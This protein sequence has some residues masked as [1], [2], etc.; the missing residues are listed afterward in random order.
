MVT[1]AISETFRGEPT[2]FR[3]GVAAALLFPLGIFLGAAF[4]LGMGA[5]SLR[6][7]TLTPWLWGINGATSVCASVI[8]IA[9]SLSFG[10]SAAFWTGAICYAVATAAFVAGVGAPARQ[11]G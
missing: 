10:I 11:A 5:A 6:H 4:P 9:I 8:A 2:W 1:P 7:P 3:I